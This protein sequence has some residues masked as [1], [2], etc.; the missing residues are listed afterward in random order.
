MKLTILFL[1]ASVSVF[2]QAPKKAKSII[3]VSDELAEETIASTLIAEGWEIASVNKYT[4]KTEPK[5]IKSW[6]F[7][8]TVSKVKDGYRISTFWSSSL[9]VYIGSGISTGP[10]SG[11][12]LNKGI[13]GGAH[14]I[15]FNAGL[16]V[17]EKFN[18]KLRYEL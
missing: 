13:N 15:G 17:A 3:I 10:Q 9:S 18:T 14:K 11:Q 1:L 5:K 6:T 16:S 4:I 7:N 12:C 2:G 8:I